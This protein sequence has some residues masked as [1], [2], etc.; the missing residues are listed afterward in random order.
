MSKQKPQKIISLI[1]LITLSV[2]FLI[3]PTSIA[4]ADEIS[5]L[6]NEIAKQ[7][8]K[9]RELEDKLGTYRDKIKAKQNQTLTLKNQIAILEDQIE[10]IKIDIQVNTEKINQTA[11]EIKKTEKEITDKE[12]KI[13]SH[14]GQL[15]E[16]IRKINQNDN[17]GYIEIFLANDNLSDFFDEVQSLNIIQRDVQVTLDN[18][19]AAKQK[20]AQHQAEL[21][22]K[23][24]GLE[25]LKS[26]LETEQAKL[27][28]SRQTKDIL[29][30]QTKNS[31]RAFK[32]LLAAAQRD[33]NQANADIA[34]LEKKVRQAL[35]RRKEL[36][37]SLDN[38]STALS[39]PTNGRQI[40][41]FFHDPDYPYRSWI[42]EH[43]AIDIRT[44][45]NGTP[46]NGL[47]IN[48]AASGYVARTKNGGAYGYSYIMLI[49]SK[50]ISTVYGH[51]SRLDVREDTYV[52]RGQQIGLSGGMPGTPGAGRFSTGPHLHFEVRLNGIPVNPLNYLP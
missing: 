44:L 47:P 38:N 12:E 22:L 31:E 41:A 26:Q 4:R 3:I 27:T 51:L 9:I 19:Q 34:S 6:E 17:L 42:G 14:K 28:S 23:K 50:G 10:K 30:S 46:T 39:W 32:N 13:T 36:G 1:L 8:S 2:N 20:L 48:A 25:A 15:A 5:I 24:K 29:L 49:H 21:G 11:L 18:V 52:A 43:P 35:R 37:G 45:R 16:F 40:V 7:K 33:Y